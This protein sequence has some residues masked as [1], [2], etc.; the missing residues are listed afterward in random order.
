MSS[1]TK[2]TE[3]SNPSDKRLKRQSTSG[4]VL[5]A[6]KEE[7]PVDG[8]RGQHYDLQVTFSRERRMSAGNEKTDAPRSGLTDEVNLFAT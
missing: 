3:R 5:A 7:N 1:G 4:D 8:H 6:I 2:L